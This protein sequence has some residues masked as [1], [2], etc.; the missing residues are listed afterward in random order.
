M[1]TSLQQTNEQRTRFAGYALT[2]VSVFLGL[3]R[4]VQ[5]ISPD[6]AQLTELPSPGWLERVVTASGSLQ[7]LAIVV[8]GAAF[9]LMLDSHEESKAM[10]VA[11]LVTFSFGTFA[12]VLALAGMFGQFFDHNSSHEA[13]RVIEAFLVRLTSLALTLAACMLTWSV[14]RSLQWSDDNLGDTLIEPDEQQ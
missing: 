8:L 11:I 13:S 9:L 3:D 1:P 4:I 2:V 12:S 6:Q 14:V 10:K 7:L 5:L